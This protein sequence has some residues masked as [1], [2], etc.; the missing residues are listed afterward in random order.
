MSNF[1]IVYDDGKQTS[2]ADLRELA[3]EGC[4]VMRSPHAPLNT[5]NLGTALLGFQTVVY[6]DTYVGASTG[7]KEE[8]RNNPFCIGERAVA[9]APGVK[10]M[11]RFVKAGMDGFSATRLTDLHAEVSS[12]AT[13]GNITTWHKFANVHSGLY[14]AI[15]QIGLDQG[16]RF[17]YAVDA[18][19]GAWMSWYGD[20]AGLRADDVLDVSSAEEGSV[21]VAPLECRLAY[22][23]AAQ[24]LDSEREEVYHLAGRDMGDYLQA[25]EAKIA[26]IVAGLQEQGLLGKLRVVLVPTAGTKVIAKKSEADTL[27]EMWA[28]S[29]RRDLTSRKQLRLLLQEENLRLAMK[30]Q[31]GIADLEA[32]GGEGVEVIDEA[33]K[34]PMAYIQHR[35]K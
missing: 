12:W 1:E 7:S 22:M 27:R 19:T 11:S 13:N 23:F 31:V 6:G 29:A 25:K 18:Q 35:L 34:I 15:V 32:M 4:S 3:D 16:L 5:A 2:Y 26:R 17:D 30:S 14:A 10:T 21:V 33:A 24:A 9:H 28:L 20:K 8:Q